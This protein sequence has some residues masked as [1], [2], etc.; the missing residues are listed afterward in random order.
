ML[1]K[2]LYLQPGELRR[3][4]PFFVLYFVLFSALTL[5]DG[6]SLTLFLQKLGAARLPQTYAI[7][8]LANLLLIGG[9]VLV[10]ERVGSVPMFHLIIGGSLAV[11]AAAWVGLNMDGDEGW[12]IVMFAGREISFALAIMH[13]G[14]VL[15]DFFSRDELN[16]VLTIVYSGGRLGGILGGL[17]LEQL[18]QP[19]GLVN[20]I[21]LFIGLCLLSAG[22]LTVIGRVFPRVH[23]PEDIHGD[24]G[25]RLPRGERGNILEQDARQTFRG[26][27]RFVW[28]SPLLF[29]NTLT[30]ILFM[31][32]R[33]ILN[34]QYSAYFERHFA[35]QEELAEFLGR[36]TQIA[37]AISLVIQLG[38]VNRLV[39]WIGIK[40]THLL[41]SAL[42]VTG[43][44]L[45]Q[46][47]M[48]LGMAVFSRVV[49]S[50]LRFGL[51]NP[52]MQLISNKFSKALR[53]RVRAWS[54]G[55]ITPVATL[56]SSL[57]LGGMARANLAAWIPTAGMACGA[58]Y[59]LCCFGLYGSFQD[60]ATA[61]DSPQLPDSDA[62]ADDS[63]T[64]KT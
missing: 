6:L 12:Y 15:Q 19:F 61:G 9:Y 55:V 40:G 5:A 26:F 23:P 49:E 1:H 13:F 53:V 41:Y 51:R 8:A 47:P 58:L 35:N 31:L 22:L 16:R 7:I 17:L 3:L 45:N 34:F 44:A 27:L 21:G 28:A 36:Y 18:A 20:L 30:S 57:L 10:A 39:A 2:L 14:T 43:V 37:L 60:G 63:G 62:V 25:V 29:W 54:F 56:T 33:W 52:I 50:E 24:P 42:L 59:L 64:R 48:T 38:L 4:L 46:L 11:F 32:C